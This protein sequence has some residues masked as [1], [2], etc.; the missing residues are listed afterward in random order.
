MQGQALNVTVVA[1][2]LIN[3]QLIELQ[4]D[5]GTVWARPGGQDAKT[6]MKPVDE[7]THAKMTAVLSAIEQFATA[8]TW[9]VRKGIFTP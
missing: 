6:R 1:G 5:C 9:A 7:Q 8:H 3:Q 4:H 2:V